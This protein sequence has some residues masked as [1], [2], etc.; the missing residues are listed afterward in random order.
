[1][2]T[3]W[4]LFSRTTKYVVARSLLPAASI[5]CSETRYSPFCGGTLNA[6]LRPC[7]RRRPPSSVSGAGLLLL[8]Y[9]VYLMIGA[10]LPSLGVLAAASSSTP[11][12][13]TDTSIRAVGRFFSRCS[14]TRLSETHSR[15][16]ARHR[17]TRQFCPSS[18]RTT[19]RKRR[20]RSSAGVSCPL[21]ATTT[22]SASP[23]HFHTPVISFSHVHTSASAPS[24]ASGAPF[25]DLG[26][27]RSM[28]RS[29][30]QAY[31]CSLQAHTVVLRRRPRPSSD[32]RERL[33]ASPCQAEPLRRP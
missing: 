3:A 31:K 20:P 27:Q 19:A 13:V 18:R 2:S 28:A 32:T 5:T 17:A 33:I 16:L 26:W 21:T 9:H 12:S 4:G 1:M 23:L 25:G 8:G 24:S 22:L 6:A 10:P 15:P 29:I 7:R 11:S 30:S 14:R